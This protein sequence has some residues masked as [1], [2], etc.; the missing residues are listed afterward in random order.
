MAAK[1]AQVVI[2]MTFL[3]RFGEEEFIP[4]ATD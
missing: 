2:L 1:T 4:S 3:Y